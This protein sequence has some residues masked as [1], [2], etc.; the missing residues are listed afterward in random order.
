MKWKLLLALALF[1]CALIYYITRKE[2][3][4]EGIEQKIPEVIQTWEEDKAAQTNTDE[5]NLDKLVNN[6]LETM[7]PLYLIEIGDVWRKGSYPKIKSD[8]DAAIKYYE[9]ASHSNNKDVAAI[10][11]AKYAEAYKDNIPDID[12]VGTRLNDI[13]FEAVVAANAAD[14]Q[15]ALVVNALLDVPDLEP[16]YEPPLVVVNQEVFLNDTQNVHDHYMTNII[17]ENIRKL[18]EAE[19]RTV[20]S[21]IRLYLQNKVR[22]DS[23]LSSYKKAEVIAI[24]DQFNN[25]KHDKFNCSETE[26]LRLVDSYIQTKDNKKDL[27]HNLFLQL[28]D[29]VSNGLTVCPTGKISRVISVVGDTEDFEDARNIYYIKQELEALAFKIRGDE[30][31][32]MTKQEVDAYN[33]GSEDIA[34][35]L[36]NKYRDAVMQKYCKELGIDEHI[37]SPLI[38][39]NLFGF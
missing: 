12:D 18:R 37:I 10:A 9:L 29:C 13:Y 14:E 21:D 33:N 6:Y 3:F 8:N 38:E 16:I 36:K 17:K 25:N 5:V 1:I 27:Y 39:I 35:Q 7:D 2:R 28:L 4:D 30:L 23:E 34:D 20:D 32:R 22:E 19:H 15:E 26:A 11:T 24:L 31:A